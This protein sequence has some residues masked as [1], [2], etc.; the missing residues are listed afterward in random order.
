MSEFPATNW[1]GLVK[2]AAVAD[3]SELGSTMSERSNQA[4]NTLCQVYW[5]P[6][7]AYAR[8]CGNS[9]EQAQDL[10]QQFWLYVLEKNL[11][12]NADRN[13]TKFRTFLLTH[14][15]YVASNAYRHGKAQK[16]GGD[17]EHLPLDFE[18][19]SER[20]EAAFAQHH[21]PNLV[22]DLAWAE[23]IVDQTYKMLQEEY[24]HGQKDLPFDAIRG[25]LQGGNASECLSY[26]ALARQYP[27]VKADAIKKRVSRLRQ[28]FREMLRAVISFTVTNPL[29]VDEEMHHLI[30]VL[31]KA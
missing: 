22:Y 30:E 29:E 16:R 5:T 23:G 10:T 15:K 13:M 20:F 18:L 17:A 9:H 7:Y 12:A 21:D 1:S 24:E 3:E 26:E 14:F 8:S 25:Y 27:V 19:T 28:R 11:I 2:L 4:F 31:S 6:I